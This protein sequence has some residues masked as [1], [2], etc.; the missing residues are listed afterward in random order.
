METPVHKDEIV[1]LTITDMTDAGEGIGRAKGFAL[2]VK[3]AVVGDRVKAKVIKVLKTYGYARLLEVEEP[4]KD[5][6]EPRCLEARRCGGCQLQALSYPTQLSFKEGQVRAA[7]E[8]IG[9]FAGED[10]DRVLA[11]ISGMDGEGE[12]PW[13]YRCKTQIP[14]GE[15]EGKVIAGFYAGRTHD[16]IPMES[17]ALAAPGTQEILDSV[18]SWMREWGIPAYREETHTGLVRHVL[19]RSGYRSGEWLVCLVATKN[20]VPHEEE[21]IARLR[22]IPGIQSISLNSNPDRTNVIL[23]R[24]NRTLWGEESIRDSLRTLQVQRTDQGFVFTP[25]EEETFFA[26]SPLSFYQVNPAQTE[27]L[28]SLVRYFAQLTGEESVWDL[29]CGVGT[30]GLT[31]ARQ[32]KSVYG[33][34]IIPAAVENARENARRN[35]ITNARFSAGKAEEVLPAHVKDTGE[36]VDVAIVDPPRK[37]CDAALLQCLLEAEPERILYVSCNPATLARDLKILT[38]GGT[39]H[40][41]AVAPVDLFPQTVHVECV[42]LLAKVSDEKG[43]ALTHFKMT[44]T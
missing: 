3:D 4:S 2:F 6:A 26:I 37:G 18:L 25:T 33:V 32:A 22:D 11:P 44:T 34:E 12:E 1:T 35:G 5:R 28:Y 30:I 39:Y 13:G 41:E 29:Y 40:L 20:T 23:G 27:K 10:V 19:I 43:D 36:R 9:G 31:L 17:C 21:L 15:R 38:E 14:I 42:V 7:L 8:R 16:I 24:E